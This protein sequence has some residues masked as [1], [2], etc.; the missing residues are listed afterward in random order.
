MVFQDY[1]IIGTK[2]VNRERRAMNAYNHRLFIA[3]GGWTTVYIAGLAGV[4]GYNTAKLTTT[5]IVP[6]GQALSRAG[7]MRY[8]SRAK[9]AILPAIAGYSLGVAIFGNY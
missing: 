2:R 4:I 9:Y 6:T 7:F 5:E 8:F 3:A 1:E